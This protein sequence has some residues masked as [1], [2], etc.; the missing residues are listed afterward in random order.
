MAQGKSKGKNPRKA[1][2]K[3]D[4]A[5]MAGFAANALKKAGKKK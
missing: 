3:K 4:A 5:Q 1:M 2:T